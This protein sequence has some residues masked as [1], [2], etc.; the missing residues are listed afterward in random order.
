MTIW[1]ALIW[2]GAILTLGGLLALG[3]CIF[4]VVRARR[5]G[6]DDE[7]LRITMRRVM[8]VNMAALGA[9]VL[10][11]MTVVLGVMLGK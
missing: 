3:W 10:G 4:A 5:S 9:S 11:L 8:A 7:Q 6:Q 2:G 1:Q